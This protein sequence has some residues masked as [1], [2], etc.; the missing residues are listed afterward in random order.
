VERSRWVRGVESGF[1]AGFEGIDNGY[2]SGLQRRLLFDGEWPLM[3]DGRVVLDDE[4]YLMPS[5]KFVSPRSAPPNVSNEGLENG[6]CRRWLLD[7]FA[8]TKRRFANASDNE[9]NKAG[10]VG[11][12]FKGWALG[13][14]YWVRHIGFA[15]LCS[16]CSGWV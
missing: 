12:G 3:M 4:W 6:W 9:A 16:T 8:S 11:F 7:D 14:T 5:A 13:S 1:E 10:S 15:V 2:G